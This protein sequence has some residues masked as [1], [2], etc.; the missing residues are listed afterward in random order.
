CSP[1]CLSTSLE[2]GRRISFGLPSLAFLILIGFCDYTA[3][4]ERIIP[5]P[6]F[7]HFGA[8]RLLLR[9]GDENRGL[10]IE[11][12]SVSGKEKLAAEILLNEMKEQAAG[13]WVV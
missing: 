10:L 11:S 9:M 12:T 3:A 1:R 13:D 2:S 4:Q 7:E 5:S 6:Q 8:R